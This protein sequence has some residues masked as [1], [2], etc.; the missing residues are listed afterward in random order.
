MPAPAS[1]TQSALGGREADYGGGGLV[2]F[3]WAIG[4]GG[5]AGLCNGGERLL[6]HCNELLLRLGDRADD[7]VLCDKE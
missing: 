5:S 4:R 1:R 2:P 7:T 6:G 3:G